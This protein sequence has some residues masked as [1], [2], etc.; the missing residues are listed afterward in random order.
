MQKN[1][2]AFNNQLINQFSMGVSSILILFVKNPELGKAKTRLAATIGDEK[3]L[4]IYKELLS[5][6]SKITQKGNFDKAVYY[7]SFIDENDF[8]D[9]RIFQKNIQHGIDLG[10][11]MK[12]AFEECINQ[13]YKN[14]CTPFQDFKIK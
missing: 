4:I 13:G 10:D 6:T 9:T 8:F 14:I 5:H 11:K 2:G 1:F 7:S 12:N 3:A